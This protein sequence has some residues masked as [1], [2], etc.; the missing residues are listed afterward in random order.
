MLRD[1]SLEHER[2]YPSVFVSWRIVCVRTTPRFTASEG[3]GRADTPAGVQH[4]NN[5]RFF[6]W[7]CASLLLTTQF[8]DSRV[9]NLPTVG[10]E[11]PR[12]VITRRPTQETTIA[13]RRTRLNMVVRRRGSRWA[14][15]I[16]RFT[17]SSRW[18]WLVRLL[19]R[20]LRQPQNPQEIRKFSYVIRS[21][22][23][24]EK[25]YF[26]AQLLFFF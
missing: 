8:Y 6:C 13:N 19:I 10:E 26:L 4:V 2:A 20:L 9:R 18:S 24:E 12:T 3:K 22:L 11:P 16:I 17:S 7:S 14:G 25:L 15:E 5:K 23:A 1:G 21:H